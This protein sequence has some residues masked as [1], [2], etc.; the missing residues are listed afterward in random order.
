MARLLPYP[1]GHGIVSVTPVSG[2]NARNSG[3]NTALDGSEQVFDTIG[4]V[5]ALR[6]DFP[7]R[8]GKGARRERGWFTGLLGGANATRFQ[9]IDGDRMT[10][11]EAGVSAAAAVTWSNN[12][13]WS[14]GQG[15]LPSYPPV[16]VTAVA[17]LDTGIIELSSNF[18]GQSLDIGD[19]IGF[20]PLHLAMYTII[21][22]ISTGKYRIWPRLRKALVTTDFAILTPTLAMRPLGV[23]AI[24]MKRGPVGTEAQSITLVEV[25]DYDARTYFGD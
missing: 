12:Q 21:E 16:P 15:W 17:A 18:W 14:S 4:D 13:N 10:L 23:S 7:F 2:P 3:S 24:S 20:M 8:R 22:V 5:V 25:F 11:V 19:H 1:E 6:L 9:F